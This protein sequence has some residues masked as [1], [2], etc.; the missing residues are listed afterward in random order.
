MQVSPSEESCLIG[1]GEQRTQEPPERWWS[2]DADLVVGRSQ[3][4]VGRLQKE[5]IRP[6]HHCGMT[7]RT[8]VTRLAVDEHFSGNNSYAGTRSQ[9][10]K[11]GG[12]TGTRYTLGDG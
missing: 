9:N 1:E 4:Y 8:D 12:F 5:K 2:Q 11:Q 3:F 6:R 10:I 7:I